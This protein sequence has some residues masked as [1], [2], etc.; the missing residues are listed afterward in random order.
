MH[1][2][3]WEIAAIAGVALLFFG[4]SRLPSLGRSVGEAIRSF[5]KGIDGLEEPSE[6]SESPGASEGASSQLSDP[7]SASEP[8]STGPDSPKGQRQTRTEPTAADSL[9]KETSKRS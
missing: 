4:P 6:K 7:A 8:G 5:K 1:L 3:F 9:E 2:G